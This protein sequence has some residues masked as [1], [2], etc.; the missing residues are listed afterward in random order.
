MSL[1]ISQKSIAKEYGRFTT[2][3]IWDF[4]ASYGTNSPLAEE[5]ILEKVDQT[6]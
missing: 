6:Q 1:Y 4:A 5:T 2:Q 3:A